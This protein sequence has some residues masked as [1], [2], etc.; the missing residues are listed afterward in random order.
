M[1]KV[2]DLL[3]IIYLFDLNQKNYC[4]N[5]VTSLGLN[6]AVLLLSRFAVFYTVS[7]L[8]LLTLPV[9]TACNCY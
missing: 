8:P 1:L 9:V 4:I 2:L 6:V 5:M 3:L 7:L